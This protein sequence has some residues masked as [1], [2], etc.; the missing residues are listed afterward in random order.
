MKP[1]MFITERVSMKNKLSLIAEY[2]LWLVLFLVLNLIFLF[3]H[4][5]FFWGNHDWDWVKG[6]TQV[7]QLNTGMFEGRYAKFILNV[8]LFDGQVIPILNNMIAFALLALGAVWLTSY[9][10]IKKFSS[11]LI[12]ALLPITAPYILG[13]LYFPINILGNFS[14][15]ALVAYGLISTKKDQW[16]YK[17]FA[18]VCFLLALGV[19]PSVAEMMIIC[20]SLHYIINSSQ[21]KQKILNSFYPILIALI[22]FKLLIFILGKLD[23]VYSGHYNLQTPNFMELIRRIPEMIMLILK[24]LV[25]TLPFLSLEYKIISLVLLMLAIFYTPK[26]WLW[27]SIAL[28]STVLSSFLAVAIEETAYAPR[29]NFYGLNFLIAGA[30]AVLLTQKHYQHNIGY[31]LALLAI[32][33]GMTSNIEASK[34]WHLGKIAETSLVTRITSEIETQSPDKMLVPVIAGELPLRP[35]YY[36]TPYQKESPYVLNGSLLVRHIPSGMFNFYTPAPL[37]Y[38]YSQIADISEQLYQFLRTVHTPWPA[39]HSLFIDEKYAVIML[40]N[41]G[42]AAIQAQLPY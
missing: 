39:S 40:T 26:K 37:F 21:N 27:W 36:A 6:T 25:T 9:W 16:Q 42:I 8:A 23:I 11:R 3:Y 5:T 28:G 12:V 38:N 22:G 34:V 10:Q 17:L 32:W 15:V 2:K 7:L 14:A 1:Y 13:W 18:V 24:Q 30:T 20:F 29:I 33:C 31:I 4:I 19:Y 41:E 35:R